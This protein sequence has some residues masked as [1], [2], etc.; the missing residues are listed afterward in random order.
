MSAAFNNVVL[1][2][3]P[4][5]TS[6]ATE[7]PSATA[8][9]GGRGPGGCDQ[10]TLGTFLPLAA[11]LMVFWFLILRPQQKRQ[12][13]HEDMLKTLQRGD[14]VRTTGGVLGEVVELGVGEVWLQIADRVK[15]NVLRANIAGKE[16]QLPDASATQGKG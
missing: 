2:F 15:V 14:K 5:P 11:M 4:E 6:A 12:R 10:G 9:A 8:P 16:G 3:Q 1:S 7:A 13:Q